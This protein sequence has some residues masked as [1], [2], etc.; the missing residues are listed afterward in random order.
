MFKPNAGPQTSFLAA[1]EREVL[2]GGSAGGGKSYAMLAD[3][4]R[5][6]YHPQFS[7]LLLRHTTEEL[8]ELIWKS[9][10]IYPKIIPGI[11]WSE[12]RMQWEAPSG[13]K[14]WMS[15]LDRDEDVMRYQGLSFSWVGLTS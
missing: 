2:Y 1:A 14:L 11:K 6:M 8:R 7:G 13:A 5:Y 10:E 9:Q 12:R 4:L 3:P 15:F